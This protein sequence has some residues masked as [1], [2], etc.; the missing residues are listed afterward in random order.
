MEMW[1]RTAT[2]SPCLD[3]WKTS[4]CSGASMVRDWVA[5]QTYCWDNTPRY[6]KQRPMFYKHIFGIGCCDSLIESLRTFLI[7]LGSYQVVSKKDLHALAK[8][9]IITLF[10][11]IVVA[12]KEIENQLGRKGTK[13]IF[14]GPKSGSSIAKS[15]V[16]GAEREIKQY[17][18]IREVHKKSKTLCNMIK[19]IA[20]CPK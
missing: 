2:E 19:N 5:I 10:Q 11:Y 18:Y 1:E 7:T 4:T 13:A 16:H 20:I 14:C 6:P 12:G 3:R 9:N 8:H 15:I 17:L